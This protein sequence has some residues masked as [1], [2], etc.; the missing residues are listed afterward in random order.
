M[1]C[2][3]LI[4][5]VVSDLVAS[6]SPKPNAVNKSLI[7]IVQTHSFAMKPTVSGF[8]SMRCGPG[9][10]NNE[11]KFRNICPKMR[12]SAAIAPP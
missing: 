5:T 7:K 10:N 9:I 8:N 3:A 12:T 2:Q 6:L 4:F 1:L 11:K